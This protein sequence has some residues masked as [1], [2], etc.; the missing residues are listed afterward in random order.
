MY[1]RHP[2]PA[3]NVKTDA[4]TFMAVLS[5]Q[6]ASTIRPM[7][8][9]RYVIRIARGLAGTAR[10]S[11]RTCFDLFKIILPIIFVMRL[12]EL[13]GAVEWLGEAIAPVMELVGLP[14]KTGLAWATAMLTNLYAGA[15]V[16]VSLD[17]PLSAAQATVLTTMMLIA[18]NLPVE[19]R[20]AQKAGTRLRIMAGL[21]IGGALLAGF[22]L[23]RIYDAGGW[24]AGPSRAVFTGRVDATWSAWLVG[25]GIFLLKVAAVITALLLLVRILKALGVMDLLARLM[26]PGL[27]MLG[28]S[29]DAAPVTVIGMTLGLAYGG[30]IIIQEARS[31]IL[32]KRDVFF[33]IALMSL[34]HSLI[35]DTILMMMLG[36][37]VTGVLIWRGVF[38]LAAVFVLVRL[39]AK[40]PERIFEKHLCRVRKDRLHAEGAE[41]AEGR[42]SKAMINTDKRG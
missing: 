28:M 14:G 31:G 36:G 21:R 16:L 2:R 37:H 30:G 15:A 39:L 29:R 3:R 9:S 38:S 6:A 4:P 40:V 1:S 23:H 19:L 11:V 13:A 20:I 34:C 17:T 41:D 8:D 32:G 24:L 10:Q 42:R 5:G 33:A 26:E 27:R 12:L 25:Q 18:H 7:R 35:E 22:V